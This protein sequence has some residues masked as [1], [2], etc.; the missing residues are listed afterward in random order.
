MVRE[1][2]AQVAVWMEDQVSGELEKLSNLEF[3]Y[4]CLAGD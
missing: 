1:E 2:A 3:V 4:S